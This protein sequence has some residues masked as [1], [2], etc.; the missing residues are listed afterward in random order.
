[1]NQ[2]L[3]GGSNSESEE[4]LSIHLAEI[5]SLNWPSSETLIYKCRVAIHSP[6]ESKPLIKELP[7]RSHPAWMLDYQH[8]GACQLKL[9]L[10][11][12]DPAQSGPW[13]ELGEVEVDAKEAVAKETS[14]NVSLPISDWDL[15]PRLRLKMRIYKSLRPPGKR[16]R[17]LGRLPRVAQ[18]K[19]VPELAPPAF[20]QPDASSYD[21]E[22]PD[23][24]PM[25]PQEKVI[26]KDSWNK[27]L[28]FKELSLDM[29]FKR[30]LA[31]EPS[32]GGRVG[33]ANDLLMENFFGLF[34]LT[35]RQLIPQTETVLREAYR[36]IH[37]SP[38]LECNT[39]E[40]YGQFFATFGLRA[41]DWLKARDAWMW[42]LPTMPY[43]EEYEAKDLEKGAASALYKYFTGRVLRPMLTALRD[44]DEAFTPDMLEKVRSG[45]QALSAGGDAPG[46]TLYGA[47]AAEGSLLAPVL[48]GLDLQGPSAVAFSS[49]ENTLDLLRD[50]DR[51]L[52]EL[53]HRDASQRRQLPTTPVEV[54][55]T[56]M[57]DLLEER[58]E[59][60]DDSQRLA[61]RSLFTQLKKE[62]R[63]P[64]TREDHVLQKATEYLTQFA[65][66]WGWNEGDLNRRLAQVRAE[67]GATGSYT[68]TYEELAFGAQL[69]WRNSSKCVGRMQWKNLLVRDMRHIQGPDEIYEECLEHL[70]V[71]NNGGRLQSVMSIFRPRRAGENWGPRIWNSQLL[72]YAGYRQSDGTILGDP[73]NAGL[74]DAILE[75]GWTPPSPKGPF[76][77]LPLVVE[78]P[79]K[80]PSVYEIPEDMVIE[81]PIE[82]PTRP[83]IGEL[84]MKWFAVPA[85]SNFRLVIG[86]VD[87]GCLPFNGWFLCT[88]IARNLTDASRYDKVEEIA[89][90]L[91]LD[92]KNDQTMWRDE[93]YLQLNKSIIHSFQKNRVVIVDQHSVSRQFL[94]HDMREKEAGRE[95]PGQWSWVVPPLGG[96]VCPVYHHEMRDFLLEPQYYHA[97]D[98]WAVQPDGGE[99]ANFEEQVLLEDEQRGETVES[100]LILFSCA[101]AGL[102]H[103]AR[104]AARRLDRFAP[105]LQSL[106]SF[107][108][109]Q[110][111]GEKMLLLMTPGTE[112][113]SSRRE[114]GKLV[115]W[116]KRQTSR[117]LKG[118]NF[119]IIALGEKDSS[120]NRQAA[121][122]ETPFPLAQALDRVLTGGGGQRLI[123]V[124]RVEAA[125]D[126]ITT[127]HRSLAM[128]GRLMGKDDLFVD[129]ANLGRH[130]R[131]SVMFLDDA[132]SLPPF[133]P[134]K[135][136]PRPERLAAR[137]VAN[138]S[139]VVG[140][141]KSL[142]RMVLDLGEGGADLRP[143]HRVQVFGQTAPELVERL[144]RRLGIQP[145]SRLT[146]HFLG[147]FGEVLGT[148]L[149]F[150][151]PI[152]VDELI[153]HELDLSWHRP[154]EDWL[155]FLWKA[156]DTGWQKET[157]EATLRL[158]DGTTG[159][160]YDKEI[161]K[162]RSEFKD[163]CDLLEHFATA[164]VSLA[165]VLELVRYQ[166]GAPF[167]VA[168]RKAEP[169]NQITILVEAGDGSSSTA[170]ELASFLTSRQ[171][172]ETVR[173]AV[174]DPS[175]SDVQAAVGEPV[176][177]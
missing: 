69:A 158:L 144:C 9:A 20:L 89:R 60:F 168:E 30:L 126:R 114:E 75:L 85:I 2:Q 150:A 162:V 112:T 6:F 66:E 133:D 88:E 19:P 134:P 52:P 54:L 80:Q 151:V 102:Q 94:T 169:G 65:E 37:P 108:A 62:R 50:W 106:A 24:V 101:D 117:P 77:M 119:V 115:E 82:H 48:R 81:V 57:L 109:E 104:L 153:A 83:E 42:V 95:C 97:A 26:V 123:P 55:E 156:V 87:Y 91:D 29:F 159:A 170:G 31:I 59:G 11:Y 47:L 167:S 124:Q 120:P 21:F 174:L 154:V 171:P 110:L 125:A 16:Q 5:T 43:I 163:I 17:G 157:L 96:S 145:E 40:E 90:A 22:V 107:D 140:A 12:R 76:D 34:D 152:R 10:L 68:H 74:T 46:R 56:P 131:L 63:Q 53:R 173:L 103:L 99:H 111:V 113:E 161:D 39:V 105:R 143:G 28:A 130:S 129:D 142:R 32:L 147:G 176:T 148:E 166:E 141:G 72:R 27:F 58:V 44:Y 86:G 3:L 128:L 8:Q 175:T 139:M 118:L 70:R 35:V 138:E 164:S 41:E 172:G 121:G 23:E 45:W 149:P 116:L 71:A 1:M 18:E 132:S 13:T 4:N 93:A 14:V 146:A 25:T 122:G 51:L 137:I 33:V 165:D 79:G 7:A 100:M 67:I 49:L 160:A 92:M 73:A 155:L 84:G 38:E 98:R 78:V 61:W 64:K 36:G 127:F 15:A 136:L 177:A 135:V